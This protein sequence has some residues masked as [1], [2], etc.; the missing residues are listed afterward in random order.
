MSK[1]TSFFQKPQF[2]LGFHLVLL[3]IFGVNLL[4]V[5]FNFQAQKKIEF[6]D[7][8]NQELENQIQDTTERDGLYESD[9]YQEKFIKDQGYVKKGEVVIDTSEIERSI[10]NPDQKKDYIPQIKNTTDNNLQKWANCF[11][12]EIEYNL[13]A[14]FCRN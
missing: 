10:D 13:D 2:I 1:K 14:T 8:K 11:F 6:L 7:R 5:F 4:Y 9:H 12:G 3:I